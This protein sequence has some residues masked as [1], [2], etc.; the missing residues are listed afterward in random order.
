MS[1]YHDI[2]SL[3]ATDT[4]IWT[5]AILSLI[6]TVL[7]VLKHRAGFGIWMLTNAGWI[8]VNVEKDIPAQA[9]LFAAYLT[10]SFWGFFAW[11]K[12]KERES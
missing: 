7:N 3:L 9:V 8:V 4:G 5:L 10:V 2:A 6:G 11:K 1:A 12:T